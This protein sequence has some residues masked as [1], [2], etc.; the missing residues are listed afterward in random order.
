MWKRFV[1]LEQLCII[2][3][4]APLLCATNWIDYIWSFVSGCEHCK[5]HKGRAG[6]GGTVTH[7]AL[8]VDRCSTFRNKHPQKLTVPLALVP[9]AK[10]DRQ[11]GHSCP[12]GCPPVFLRKFIEDVLLRDK[13]SGNLP[14]IWPEL[15]FLRSEGN[16][17]PDRLTCENLELSK[18]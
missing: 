10:Q 3:E 2:H 5:S 17:S 1:D 16:S 15:C 9:G 11:W 8:Q 13:C 7:P 14:S 6:T 4:A 12:A 18:Q